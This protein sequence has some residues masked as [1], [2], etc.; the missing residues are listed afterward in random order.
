M[1]LGGGAGNDT[2]MGGS[3]NDDLDGG[4]GDDTSMGVWAMIVC[5]AVTAMTAW[6]AAPATTASVGVRAMIVL[7]GGDGNDTS[8][9]AGSS[10]DVVDARDGIDFV[11]TVS[12]GSGTDETV[13]DDVDTMAG[14]L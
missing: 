12:C 3:S 4:D 9:T 7:R 10:N 13:V 8:L 11:D 6:T 1:T 14:G 5:G 2:L